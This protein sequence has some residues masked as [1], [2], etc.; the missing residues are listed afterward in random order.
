MLRL[1]V[2]PELVKFFSSSNYSE[3]YW[4]HARSF[5]CSALPAREGL[6]RE[7]TMAKGAECKVRKDLE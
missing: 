4:S 1:W 3:L 7:A 5:S 6:N 2:G